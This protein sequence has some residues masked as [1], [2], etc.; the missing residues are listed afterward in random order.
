MLLGLSTFLCLP[1][2]ARHRYS[3]APQ[4]TPYSVGNVLLGMLM[5]RSLPQR[6]GAPSLSWPHSVPCSGSLSARDG[7]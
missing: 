6:V 4:G 3:L 2:W 7:D 1:Y 5:S